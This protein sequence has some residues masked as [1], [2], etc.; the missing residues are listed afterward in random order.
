MTFN[1][2]D[3]KIYSPIE[4]FF[5]EN[6]KKLTFQGKEGILTILPNHIDYVSSFDTNVINVVDKDN[7]EKFIA[8][9]NGILTKYADKIRL[10]AYK[11][12]VGNNLNELKE[13][14]KEISKN[15]GEL[16]KEINKNLKQLEYYMLNNL[17]ELK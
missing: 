8:L 14:I 13:K 4:M 6:I 3:L 1:L 2:I 11:V 10:T 17:T 12:I 9:S 16:E 7:K 15:E 5:D